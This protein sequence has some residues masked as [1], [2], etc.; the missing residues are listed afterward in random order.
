M[1]KNTSIRKEKRGRTRQKSV[2]GYAASLS[3]TGSRYKRSSGK[4]QIITSHPPFAITWESFLV[5]KRTE[6]ARRKSTTLFARLC[7]GNLIDPA[8][9]T[10]VDANRTFLFLLRFQHMWVSYDKIPFLSSPPWRTSL[11]IFSEII[12]FGLEES[13]LVYALPFYC[14][15]CVD[16]SLRKWHAYGDTLS[17]QIRETKWSR[18]LDV[19]KWFEPS[20]SAE[21]RTLPANTR[22][23]MRH[24]KEQSGSVRLSASH[25]TR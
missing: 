15:F 12:I 20:C 3:N 13:S 23:S 17:N 1:N 2:T 18:T 6:A 16:F 22:E 21:W 11:P 8:A 24:L 7:A 9:T 10:H 19:G 25:I 4:N 14:S 5:R